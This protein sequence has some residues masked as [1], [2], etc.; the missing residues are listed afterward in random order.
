MGSPLVFGGFNGWTVVGDR[1]SYTVG[2][3]GYDDFLVRGSWAAADAVLTTGVLTGAFSVGDPSAPEAGPFNLEQFVIPGDTM[4]SHLIDVTSE[5][6]TGAVV[7]AETVMVCRP[8]VAEQRYLGQRAVYG[9]P[10]LIGENR[11]QQRF[12][13][14]RFAGA[15]EFIGQVGDGQMHPAIQ[16]IGRGRDRG[17]VS[18]P[19]R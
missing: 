16:R 9:K 17:G 15:M 11:P 5:A 1:L 7:A 8:F 14:R 10:L 6:F 3:A 18:H 13:G 19:H 2:R 4:G 12:G